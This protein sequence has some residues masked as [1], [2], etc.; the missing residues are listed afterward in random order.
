M[1]L[2]EYAQSIVDEMPPSVRHNLMEIDKHLQLIQ[3]QRSL[4]N[5]N[6]G[7]HGLVQEFILHRINALQPQPKTK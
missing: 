1:D 7:Q 5:L 3:L 4:N 6:K 2:S